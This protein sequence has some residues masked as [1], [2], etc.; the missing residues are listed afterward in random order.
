MTI[1]RLGA[2]VVS[3]SP[4]AR[5]F[6][7]YIYIYLKISDDEAKVSITLNTVPRLMVSE[8]FRPI[9]FNELHGDEQNTA[10]QHGIFIHKQNQ[11]NPLAHVNITPTPEVFTC[12]TR[13]GDT[14]NLTISNKDNLLSEL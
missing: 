7:L 5:Q 6:F 11:T 14:S 12:R 2:N 10:K 9:L 4:A 1:V 3:S 13:Q 8:I